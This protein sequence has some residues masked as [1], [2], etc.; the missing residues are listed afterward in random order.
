MGSVGYHDIK[1]TMHCNII[2]IIMWFVGLVKYMI[3]TAKLWKQCSLA[4]S[5][6]MKTEQ[7]WLKVVKLEIAGATIS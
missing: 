6:A 5:M 2:S 3:S 4:M 7:V 1:V